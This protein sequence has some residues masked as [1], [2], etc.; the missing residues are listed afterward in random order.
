MD[1][2]ALL[3]FIL[4]HEIWETFSAGAAPRLAELHTAREPVVGAPGMRGERLGGLGAH[5]P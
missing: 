5:G 4:T 2:P 3:V 1:S